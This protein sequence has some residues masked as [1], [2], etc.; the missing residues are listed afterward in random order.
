VTVILSNG[1]KLSD[2]RIV[3]TYKIHL[4]KL[5]FY[6]LR[7]LLHFSNPRINFQE[8]GFT[9]RY[10]NLFTCQRY[11]CLDIWRVYKLYHTNTYK[12]LPE[13]EPWCSKRVEDIIKIKLYF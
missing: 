10:D 4:F 6:F 7:Y 13:D 1:V 2:G 11:D 12:R 3:Q 9:Y 5:I 8:A